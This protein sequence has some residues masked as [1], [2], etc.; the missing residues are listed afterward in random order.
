MKKYIIIFGMALI[1][2]II[3]LDGCIEEETGGIIKVSEGH[4]NSIQSAIDAASNNDKILVYPGIYNETIIINKSIS[5]I[6]VDKNST[7]IQYNGN[8][9]GITVLE[10]NADDCIVDGFVILGNNESTKLYPFGSLSSIGIKVQSNN[11]IITNNTIQDIYYGI[12]LDNSNN[13][14]VSNNNILNNDVGLYIVRSMNNKILSN[15]ITKNSIFGVYISSLLSQSDKNIF[16]YNQI[17]QNNIGLRIKGSLEN[18]FE[19]NIVQNN[20]DKGFLF[21]CGSRNNIVF[22]NNI[23]NN[24]LNADDHY[25]NQWHYNKIGNYWS[26]YKSKYPNSI[27]ENNDGFWDTPYIIYIINGDTKDLFPLVKSITIL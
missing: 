27:D 23:I 5:L 9:T 22:N 21:C 8:E 24:S 11:N 10:I 16:K 15:N 26:D 17:S 1:L 7:T 13:T 3:A 19:K 20:D 18:K 2:I 4:F 12:H 14:I 25:H 6:A